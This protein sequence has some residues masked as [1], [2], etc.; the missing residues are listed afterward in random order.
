MIEYD[1][2]RRMNILPLVPEPEVVE[3][4]DL[5]KSYTSIKFGIVDVMCEYTYPIRLV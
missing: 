5:H 3:K 4:K 2:F 1:L